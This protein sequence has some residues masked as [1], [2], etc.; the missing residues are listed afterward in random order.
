MRHYEK[1]KNMTSL[2]MTNSAE[3]RLGTKKISIS[4]LPVQLIQPLLIN[5]V[6]EHVLNTETERK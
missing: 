6:T 3:L 2:Q 5:F 1:M 4:E